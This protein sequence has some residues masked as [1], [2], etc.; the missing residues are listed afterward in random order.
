MTTT[1]TTIAAAVVLLVCSYPN[2]HTRATKLPEGNTVAGCTR[3][4]NDTERWDKACATRGIPTPECREVQGYTV[5]WC[6][7]QVAP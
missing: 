4:L 5:K 6:R 1:A 3:F 7:C 2:G